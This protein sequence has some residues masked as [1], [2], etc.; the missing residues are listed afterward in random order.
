MPVLIDSNVLLDI[1]VC[2]K[3]WY[4]WS[5]SALKQCADRDRLMI[6]PIIYAEISAGFD[7]IEG[8]E[9]AV[10][11]SMIERHAIPYEASFLAGKCFMQYRKRGGNKTSPLP[12]FFIGAH[13]AIENWTLLTRDMGRYTTYFP[14]LELITP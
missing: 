4:D 10:P 13:A 8:V 5:S 3:Q 1:L 2:D 12:D 7:T 9:E 14:S 6:N 11:A